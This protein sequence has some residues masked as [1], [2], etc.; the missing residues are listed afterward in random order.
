MS[1]IIS[2]R[3]GGLYLKNARH[4]LRPTTAKVKSY[5]FNV[6]YSL[7][8]KKVL[9][10]FAGS[11]ALG[12]EALS[13]G[14]AH[15]SFV[16]LD[17]RS[18]RLIHQNLEQVGAGQDLWTVFK[19]NALRFICRNDDYYDIILADP[20]Y[21]LDLTADFLQNCRARLNPQGMLILEYGSFRNVP[22]EA[23]PPQRI[24]K[25]GDTTIR[26]YVSENDKE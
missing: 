14:A 20:P 12:I 3:Y 25:M 6:L 18:L 17:S 24:K 23:W 4:N 11:G 26:M 5:I 9:D 15:V 16:D 13:R 1:R 22:D 19:D 7:D 10:I 2:G 8:G 21:G